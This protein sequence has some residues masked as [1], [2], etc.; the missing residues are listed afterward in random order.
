MVEQ[1]TKKPQPKNLP[2]WWNRGPLGLVEEWE[3]RVSD[4][5]ITRR[6]DRWRPASSPNAKPR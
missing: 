5:E 4:E 3:N 2:T 6:Q 1:P